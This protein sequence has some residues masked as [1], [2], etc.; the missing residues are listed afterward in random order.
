MDLS[1]SFIKSISNIYDE[2]IG[3]GFSLVY[4]GENLQ[5]QIVQIGRFLPQRLRSFPLA[6]FLEE[7]FALRDPPFVVS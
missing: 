2:M 4:L 1:F 7:L 6:L 3:N 5:L